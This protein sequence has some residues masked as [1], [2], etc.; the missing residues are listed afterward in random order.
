MNNNKSEQ[1]DKIRQQFDTSPFPRIPIDQS[2]KDDVQLLYLHNLTTSYYLRNQKVI[3]S[4]DKIILDAGC[5]TGYKSLVLAEANPGA[6]IVGIDISE[7]S[8]K[9]ARQRLKYH[10]F[11]NTEFYTLSIYDL[12][13]LNYQFDYINCD[14]TLYLLPDLLLAL[15][16]MKAVLN[17]DGII[18][19]NLHNYHIRHNMLRAQEL[20]SFLGV[21]DT[22]P[23]ELEAKTV[24]E[25]MRSFNDNVNLKSLTW[26]S[27]YE[28]EN[29]PERILMN[30]L[31]QGDKGFTINDLFSALN[32]ANLVLSRWGQK[33]T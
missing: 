9:L 5:G 31:L 3:D 15:K 22:T 4:K 1:W 11:E 17:P 13:E 29:Q 32:E 20:F 18:R 25:V 26:H 30:F 21:V 6:K 23:G 28:A 7:E 8:V 33:Q 10:G 14:E 2:P 19:G 24:R 12:P 27:G 16:A